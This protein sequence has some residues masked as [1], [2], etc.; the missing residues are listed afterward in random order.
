M[1]DAARILGLAAPFALALPFYKL[2]KIMDSRAS[3]IVSSTISAWIKGKKYQSIELGNS[4]ISL[5]ESLYGR[6]LLSIR[7]I[8]AS[9]VL[10]ACATTIYYVYLFLS[11][12]SLYPDHNGWK[13]VVVVVYPIVAISD[14]ISLFIVKYSLRLC[15][16]NAKKGI[17]VATVAG[18]ATII[19]AIYIEAEITLYLMRDNPIVRSH[20]NEFFYAP[21]F[22]MSLSIIIAPAF[23]VHLWLPLFLLGAA[24]SSVTHM[25]FMAVGKTQWLIAHGDEHPIETIGI[26]ASIIVFVGDIVFRTLSPLFP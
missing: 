8:A 18:I 2:F 16:E 22:L 1:E 9:L 19:A 11:N 15:R 12:P 25:F 23:L 26:M 13:V 20:F 3:E 10:T 6:R 4:I 17:L 7:A 24:L 14:Y 21:V 5:F